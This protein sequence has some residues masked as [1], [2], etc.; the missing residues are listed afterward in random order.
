MKNEKAKLRI[1]RINANN[2]RKR[3]T[4]RRIDKKPEKRLKDKSIT[5]NGANLHEIDGGDSRPQPLA[6]RVGPALAKTVIQRR[7]PGRRR[8]YCSIGSSTRDFHVSIP[9]R[10]HVRLQRATEAARD[11]STPLRMT[12]VATNTDCWPPGF[13]FPGQT[14]TKSPIEAAF[15]TL[16]LKIPRFLDSNV[17]YSS[18]MASAGFSPAARRVCPATMNTTIDK[19]G[20]VEKTNTSAVI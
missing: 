8:I 13:R 15:R 17:H 4:K 11:F 7:P 10:Q 1:T 12:C 18:R 5:T 2:T 20:R 9:E 19:A 3:K 6:K 16:S 14:R